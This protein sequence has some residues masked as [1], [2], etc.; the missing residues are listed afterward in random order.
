MRPEGCEADV[1]GRA[2]AF[3]EIITALVA[4][5]AAFAAFLRRPLLDCFSI[6]TVPSVGWHFASQCSRENW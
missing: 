6:S 2:D 5:I 4:T 1:P 3:S